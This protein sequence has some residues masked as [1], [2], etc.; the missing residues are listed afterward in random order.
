MQPTE[1]SITDLSNK[2]WYILNYNNSTNSS[3]NHTCVNSNED[4]YLKKNDII[5]LGRVKYCLNEINLQNF[6][7]NNVTH[8]IFDSYNY[9]VN[10]INSNTSPVFDFIFKAKSVENENSEE[11]MCKICYC[12]SNEDSNP[13]VHLCNCS[14]GIRFAHYFCIKKWM[15]TKLSIKENEK[16]TVKSYSIRSF[17]CEICK[18][19][20]PCKL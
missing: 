5:K 14:G 15:E 13:L 7:L 1:K 12:N 4:Y 10:E 3:L 9:N 18:T 2:I 8:P 17:N 6:D 16:K 19:P 20:Y 11:S